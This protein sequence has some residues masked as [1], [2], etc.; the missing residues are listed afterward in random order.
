MMILLAFGVILL[1]LMV[2]RVVYAKFEGELR[3]L[4]SQFA[5]SARGQRGMKLAGTQ[6]RLGLATCA[7][8]RCARC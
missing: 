1:S 7:P 3:K 2:M 8:P 5:E 6:V 4:R